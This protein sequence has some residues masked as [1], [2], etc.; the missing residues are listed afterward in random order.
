M[1]NIELPLQWKNYGYELDEKLG[2]G[3]YGAVY[4]LVKKKGTDEESYSALKL[5][6][7]N[8]SKKIVRG[9]YENDW[10]KARREYAGIINK[11]A[12]EISIL[13]SLSG[14]K[15]IV[16]IKGS[17]LEKMPEENFWRIYIQME[18]LE[19]LMDYLER[20]ESVEETEVIRL[21]IEI[22]EALHICHEKNIIHRDIK[23]D[24]IMVAEDGTFK[25]GD[26]GVAREQIDGSMTVAGTY[27]F[28]APE[29]V[30][31][32]R[33]DTSA[34]LY[35][36]G[37][38]LYYLLNDYRLPYADVED[39]QKRIQ[40]RIFGKQPLPAPIHAFEGMRKVIAK[41]CASDPQD[42]YS[43]AQKMRQDLEKVREYPYGKCPVCRKPLA[44][45]KGP[46]GE[47]LACS[48]FRKNRSD[49]CTY[50]ISIEKYLNQLNQEEKNQ[51]EEQT[52][53]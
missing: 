10:D 39:M 8:L 22:C 24:N 52:A 26:F 27:D 49:S 18:Y 6:S 14:E 43:S 7:W 32:A 30:R 1:E 19:S 16:Q 50:R 53:E 46:Y 33:Y 4:R 38:V 9:T 2:E 31:T 36:L 41:A 13:E 47:F 17:C 45:K 37:L 44:K 40:M 48:G 20:K 15:H 34:D 35:S 5:I 28:V 3:S 42:R 29:V 12:Q 21:G 51:T 25:L 11:A 23:P